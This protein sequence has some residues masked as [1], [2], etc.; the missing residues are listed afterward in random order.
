MTPY[1]FLLLALDERP[2]DRLFWVLVGVAV[3]VQTFGAA[4]FGRFDAFYYD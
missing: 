4:T 2:L 1:L 3:V